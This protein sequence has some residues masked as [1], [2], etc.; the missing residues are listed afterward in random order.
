[1]NAD[2]RRVR[3][4]ILCGLL[5]GVGGWAW[6]AHAAGGRAPG[7]TTLRFEYDATTYRDRAANRD[8][9]RWVTVAAVI[10]NEAKRRP[11]FLYGRNHEGTLAVTF[12]DMAGLEDG[13][14]VS[15]TGTA[16][17]RADRYSATR[18]L[19]VDD[20][21]AAD[22]V[23]A[24][25][26]PPVFLAVTALEN[27]KVD[28]D[29]MKPLLAENRPSDARAR[30]RRRAT[31]TGT[32]VGEVRVGDAVAPVRAP[33]TLTFG[34]AADHYGMTLVSRIAVRGAD[35]GLGGADADRTLTMDWRSTAFAPF[36]SSQR[37]PTLE[38]MEMDMDMDLGL[39]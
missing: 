8:W 24:D 19:D 25:P 11:L 7:A 30:A 39:D 26:M 2:G 35:V 21:A 31:Y 15:V 33:V 16:V 29:G 28:G 20:F 13:L 6:H 1:M 34:E 10:R 18:A 27:L 38:T 3:T 37:A 4:A 32:L 23:R 5:L 14:R 12:D 36:P 17:I 9:P 22:W